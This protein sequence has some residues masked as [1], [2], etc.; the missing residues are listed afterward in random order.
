[1]GVT[2]GMVSLAG[3][4]LVILYSPPPLLSSMHGIAGAVI[5]G[6]M[7]V[8]IILGFV[9]NAMF[10]PERKKVATVDKAHWWLGRLLVLAG[11]GN[12]QLGFMIYSSAFPLSSYFVITHWSI[13]GGAAIMFLVAEMKVG[14]VNHVGPKENDHEYGSKY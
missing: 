6:L 1:M 5:T 13:V 8:Q 14:Q 7:I 3:V 10:D 4:A 12:C 2:T 11:I 9:A